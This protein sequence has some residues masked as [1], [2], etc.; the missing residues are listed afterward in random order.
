V[1]ISTHIPQPLTL[2][3]Y[4]LSPYLLQVG[5]GTKIAVP[6]RPDAAGEP[7]PKPAA[8]APAAAAAP[9]AAPAPPAADAQAAAAA[10]A[11]RRAAV[12]EAKAKLQAEQVGVMFCYV[13]VF[14][15]VS[16]HIMQH[17][18]GCIDVKTQS[19]RASDVA[20]LRF[21]T[22]SIYAYRQALT[23]HD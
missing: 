9:R 19:R 17:V 21:K 3:L 8:A 5:E 16:F 11:K 2:P 15:F 14:F 7:A 10:E 20:G 12:E 6:D 1:H 4:Y 13:T 18:F 22:C 23:A